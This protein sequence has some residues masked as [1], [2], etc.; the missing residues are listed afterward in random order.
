MRLRGVDLEGFTMMTCISCALSLGACGGTTP[1][2]ADAEP[3][4]STQPASANVAQDDSGRQ[5]MLALHMGNYFWMALE[6]RDALIAGHLRRAKSRMRMLSRQEYAAVIPADWHADVQRMLDAAKR[7]ADA[8][9]LHQASEALGG[10]A[11]ACGTCH[12]KRH[13]G[14]LPD[15]TPV[16][17]PEKSGESL[18]ERM[19]RHQWAAD[20]LWS[21]L[22]SPSDAE[23]KAGAEA[24][25]DAPLL[26]P[27]APDGGA[28][29]PELQSALER[30]RALG[31]RALDATEPDV[32]AKVYGELL[33]SC[34]GCHTKR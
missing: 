31:R 11:V 14:P 28:V 30:V 7:V 1:A 25:L 3:G 5:H 6:A 33:Q 27:A 21:A 22:T 29:G 16:R 34:S 15:R 32:R 18:T 9:D 12:K 26:P 19:L 10:L 4:A 20:A 23:W 24:L 8:P 13:A 17:E 2:P